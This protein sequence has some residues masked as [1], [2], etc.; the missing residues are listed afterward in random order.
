MKIYTLYK[1]INGRDCAI[2]PVYIRPVKGG[3]KVKFY[4]MN[5][6][7]PTITHL[8]PVPLDEKIIKAVD[9]PNWIEIERD[10][11]PFF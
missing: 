8:V 2:F 3:L 9:L 4:W 6:S 11:E 10:Y 1:H 7:S 5:I